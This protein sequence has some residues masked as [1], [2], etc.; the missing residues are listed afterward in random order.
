MELI[1]VLILN[2]VMIQVTDFLNDLQA[3]TQASRIKAV[4]LKSLK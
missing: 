4:L 3:Q 2:I 1:D